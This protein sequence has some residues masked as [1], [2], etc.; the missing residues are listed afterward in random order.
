VTKAPIGWTAA[1]LGLLTSGITTWAQ[2]PGSANPSDTLLAAVTVTA[3]RIPEPDYNVPASID[4]EPIAQDALGVNASESLAFVP[5][6]IVRDR[7][8]Y[9]QDEQISIRGFGAR[10][11]F[12]I[13]GIRV[14]MDGIPSSQPDGQGSVSQFDLASAERIEVLRGPFSVLYGNSAGGVIQLFTAN[15]SGPLRANTSVVYGSFDERRINADVEGGDAAFNYNVGAS[16]FATD[17]SRGHSAAERSSLG[18]KWGFDFDGAGKLT[19]LLNLFDGPHAQDPLGLTRAQFNANPHGT[20]PTAAEFN[21]RKSA[22]QGQLGAIYELPVNDS[23]TVSLTT[24]GGHRDVLQFQA[25]PVAT[26]NA[27]TS[28][29]GV[30]S[31]SNDYGGVEPRWVYHAELLGAPWNVTAGLNYDNLSEH[32]EGYDNFIGNV[33]GVQGALRRNE[34]DDVYDLDQYLQ[35]QWGPIKSWTVFA[36]VRR[37]RLYFQSTA[38]YVP[39]PDES[40]N[41]GV[42]YGATSPV[43]GILFQVDQHLN[44]YGSYGQGF[45]TPTLDELAYR[46]SGDPGLNLSLL[47]A[48]SHSYEAGAKLRFDDANGGNLFSAHAALFRSDLSSELI[49]ASDTGGRSIYG[50]AGLTRHQGVELEALAHLAPALQ[51]HLAYTYLDALVETSYL[52]CSA[53]PCAKP[54]TLVPAGNRIPGLPPHDV[55]AGLQWQPLPK[56]SW[57]FTDTYVAAFFA[58]DA[59]MNYAGAYNLL[60]LITDYTWSLDAGSLRGFVRLDNLLNRVYA[61]SVIVNNTNAEYY[62]AGP[63]RAVLVGVSFQMR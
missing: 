22:D 7:Q 25:I 63:G 56:W 31:L 19:L 61:G 42:D 12:N 28:P 36:G 8:N 32:R 2:E 16:Y 62:E 27:P 51:F 43:G 5:G 4:S 18:G 39:P 1:A 34:T 11:P 6:L 55:Y 54:N 52:T 40:G 21:T 24:Y 41:G 17:G 38:L 29:G 50:N 26:Q 47:A 48:R 58:D 35:T 10:A 15:G 3:T 49:L 57:T 33:L 44:L 45:E 23:N 13:A 60:G 20:A 14:Y 59:N 9:A 30:V 37:S 46:P 53:V